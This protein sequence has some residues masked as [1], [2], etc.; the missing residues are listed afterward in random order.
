[1]EANRKK[2]TTNVNDL[3]FL[4]Y[5][6][7]SKITH[8]TSK[9]REGSYRNHIMPTFGKEAVSQLTSYKIRLWK[10][11][12]LSKNLS[13]ATINK[14]MIILGQ[15]VDIAYELNIEGVPERRKLGLKSL[16]VIPCH[17]LFL[18]NDQLAKLRAECAKSSNANLPT[19]IDLLVLTG[20]RKREILDAT[21]N[22]IDFGLRLL[23]V[24]YSKNGKPRHITL[25]ERALDI[26][27]QLKA[28][29]SNSFYVIPN[30]VSGEPYRCFFHAWNK[31]RIAAG[32]PYLRVH[33]LRH[34]FA[35]ALVNS[36]ISLYEVQELLGHSSIKTTQRYAHLDQNRLQKSVENISAFYDC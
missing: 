20:A 13:P 26:L 31:A 12:L 10:N 9:A 28:R 35:S 1:M 7:N 22:N 3:F 34:S 29:G 6:P 14:L 24:P 11:S 25:C 15:L 8:K 27:S 36:G 30:P 32:L 17:D 18:R 21:W 2:S 19:I 16:E 23:T 33:D 4:H 5:L